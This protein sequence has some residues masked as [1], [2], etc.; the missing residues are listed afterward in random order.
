MNCWFSAFKSV[1]F[2]VYSIL[3]L[4]S[5]ILVKSSTWKKRDFWRETAVQFRKVENKSLDHMGCTPLKVTTHLS[6]G[7]FLG[8]DIRSCDLQVST[9]MNNI[10]PL[11][12]IFF[13][14]FFSSSNGAEDEDPGPQ[15]T[16]G[17]IAGHQQSTYQIQKHIQVMSKH[18]DCGGRCTNVAFRAACS[19]RFSTCALFLAL[20]SVILFCIF[21]LLFS[22][23]DADGFKG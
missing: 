9:C 5:E 22:L 23:I 6:V 8:V 2:S 15:T 16:V 19:V 12:I 1:C 21:F 13:R 14:S 3:W 11:L 18:S 10:E 17:S 20:F 4:F 7:H